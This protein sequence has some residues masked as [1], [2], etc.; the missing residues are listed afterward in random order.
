MIHIASVTFPGYASCDITVNGVDAGRT[1]LLNSGTDT[2]F[3]I[4]VPARG[5]YNLRHNSR[6]PL[7]EGSLTHDGL[8]SLAAIANSD[9]R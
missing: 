2:G 8:N 9:T 1:F 5:N 4:S 7:S 6:D 3:A